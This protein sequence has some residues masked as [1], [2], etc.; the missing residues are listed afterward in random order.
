MILDVVE[1]SGPRQEVIAE[2]AG[3]SDAG[4]RA[5]VSVTA[6]QGRRALPS[7]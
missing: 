1:N 2:D 5:W 3:L 4:I 6:Y 7:W